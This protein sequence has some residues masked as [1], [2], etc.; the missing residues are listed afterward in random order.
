MQEHKRDKLSVSPPIR[1]VSDQR[2][3]Q[4]K[5]TVGVLTGIDRLVDVKHVLK[6]VNDWHSLGLELGLLYPTLEKIKKTTIT[7]KLSN[8]K[9]R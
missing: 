7:A 4:H 1:L 5:L 2:T 6:W 8:A 9:K 3:C